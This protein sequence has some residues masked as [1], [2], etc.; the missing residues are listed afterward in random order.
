MRLARCRSRAHS[1]LSAPKRGEMYLECVSET[2]QV[3]LSQTREVVVGFLAQGRSQHSTYPIATDGVSYGRQLTVIPQLSIK[4][5]RHIVKPLGKCRLYKLNIL[6]NLL[7]II[8]T[9]FLNQ[10]CLERISKVII[11]KLCPIIS[12]NNFGI[13]SPFQTFRN[14]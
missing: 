6:L 4:F 11:K 3:K 1:A 9:G 12:V 14:S 7:P 13:V 5:G 2:A 8:S 10:K